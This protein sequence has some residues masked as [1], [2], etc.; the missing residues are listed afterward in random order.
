MKRA[1]VIASVILLLIGVGLTHQSTKLSYRYLHAP[2]PGFLPLWIGIFLIVLSAALLV[3]SL[4][5]APMLKTTWPGRQMAFK[6]IFIVMALLL[7]IFVMSYLGYAISTV[8]FCAC[9]IRTLSA[10]YTWVESLVISNAMAIPIVAVFDIWFGVPLPKGL[11]EEAKASVIL[12]L[13]GIIS[14]FL[15]VC[16]R[17]KKGVSELPRNKKG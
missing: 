4:R 8:F 17:L 6:L 11:F 10:R 7:Y 14:I 15:I 12:V 3:N 9:L 5:S 16:S 1:E 13:L 2:G